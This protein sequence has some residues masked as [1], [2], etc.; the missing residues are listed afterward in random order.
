MARICGITATGEGSP[1]RRGRN[2]R[3]R[4][5]HPLRDRTT[6]NEGIVPGFNPKLLA[7]IQDGA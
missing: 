7:S 1:S 2:Y 4:R 3:A 6:L 5:G